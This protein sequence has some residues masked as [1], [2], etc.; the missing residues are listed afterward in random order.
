MP[1]RYAAVYH[2]EGTGEF[3]RAALLAALATRLPVRRIY[4]AELAASDDWHATTRV[5]VFPGGA[6]R[7][8]CRALNGAGNA[9][10]Q[11]YVERGGAMLGVC[12]GAY[13][14][15]RRIAFESGTPNAIEE[16]RELALFSGTAR[17]SL[18]DLAEPYS[19]D[20]LRCATL[21]PL[22]IAGSARRL[23]A[24]YWGG[25]ELVPDPHT[26]YEPLLF[27]DTDTPNRLAAVRCPVGQGRAVLCGVHAEVTGEQFPIE[28]SRYADDSFAHGMQLAAALRDAD[29]ERQAVF[30]HLLAAL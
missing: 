4:A 21:A 22:R 6:D 5:L 15:S 13:Y 23:H 14:I 30:D 1:E 10:V 27:Y 3:S 7:P 26:R 11:R 28:V 16:P 9:S 19:L 24:L 12:A 8:Y 29:A 20:H 17:G 25:P 18:H 2:D